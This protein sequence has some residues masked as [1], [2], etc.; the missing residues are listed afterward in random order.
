MKIISNPYLLANSYEKISKNARALTPGTD[1]KTIEEMSWQRIE[2]I[3]EQLK[4]G[5][6]YW[7]R[8]RRILISKPG[9]D[10]KRPLIVPNIEDRIVQETIRVILEAIYEPPFTKFELSHGFRPKHL[11]HTAMERIYKANFQGIFAL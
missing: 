8:G 5:T 4:N 3:S 2:E 10:K 6:Y 9:T 7:G 1:E 11:C